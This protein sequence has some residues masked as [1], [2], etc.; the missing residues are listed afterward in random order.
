[1]PGRMWGELR[2]TITRHT[3]FGKISGFTGTTGHRQSTLSTGSD[4]GKQ[5]GEQSARKNKHSFES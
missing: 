3:R 2:V 4:G 5:T 1:M